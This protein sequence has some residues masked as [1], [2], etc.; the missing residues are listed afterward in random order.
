M[1]HMIQ[2]EFLDVELNG[3]ESDAL[4]LQRTLP[5]L[6][7]N[8]LNPAIDRTL[9]R[10]MP[11]VGNLCI[12]RMEL[13]LGTM[14]LERLERDLPDSMAQAL[15]KWLHQH[16][17]LA[18]GAWSASVAAR[19]DASPEAVVRNVRHKTPLYAVVEALV[20]FL[21]NG[22]LPWSFRL[23]GGSTLE[24]MTLQY[25]QEETK[26]P[27]PTGPGHGPLL[28]VLA[29]PNARKR[30]VRQF[31]PH[32]LDVLLGRLAP[33]SAT[34]PDQ[35]REERRLWQQGAAV[36]ATSSPAGTGSGP[37]AS[38]REP[39]AP[40]EDEHPEART[41]LF[42]QNAGLVLLHPFL[43]RLFQALGIAD[44]DRLLD[45]ERAL[46]LLHYLATGQ[47][48]TPEY[49]LA[50][51][52]ILCG[53]PLPAPVAT[54]PA[55][56]APEKE[57]AVALLEAVIGHWE[58]LRNSSPDEL[59]GVFLLR[60]GKLSRRDDGDWLLQVESQACDILLDKL[61]WGYSAIKLPWM[62][63]MLWVEWG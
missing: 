22:T 31:S 15:E 53:L 36:A 7:R 57:E 13:D 28:R 41:G 23:P 55:L 14:Q 25:W 51:P 3:T 35:I 50:L 63:R 19:Q 17:P 8:W 40:G 42:L 20:H 2:Q 54:N 37:G 12:E 45:P 9:E 43:P 6:C 32:F 58:A 44:Q 39:A 61:P 59:R 48:L 56:S 27:L 4:A 5:E 30:L 52:K 60:P 62:E 47:C 26:A 38:A 24:Q 49:E 1:T 29:E 10:R 21:R 46:G 33:E 34:I 16:A 11:P 18:G